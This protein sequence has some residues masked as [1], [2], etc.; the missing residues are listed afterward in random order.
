MRE[1]QFELLD[2]WSHCQFGN[3]TVAGILAKEGTLS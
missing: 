1:T 3:V 2:I